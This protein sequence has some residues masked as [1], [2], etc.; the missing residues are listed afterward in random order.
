MLEIGS[1]IDG[2]YKILNKIGQGGMSVVYLAMNERAN[3]QWAI[4]EVRKDGV[5]NFEV[6]KQGLVAEV[7]MLKK[8]NHPHLPSI[9]DV[10]DGDDSFLIVMDYI[11]GVSLNKKLRELGAIPQ[12]NVIE[13]GKQLCDV[14][15]YL[16]SRTAP[17]IY[18]DM[19]P[20][21]VMLRPDGDVMLIDFG[22]AREFKSNSVADT[23][24]LG[25]QGYAAPEQFGGQGQTDARTDIYCLGATL[26]HL[27]TG[28]NPCEY[29][30]EMYP[31]RQ[32]NP[33]LSSGLEQIIQKCTQ[34]NPNDRYQSCAELM[35]ALDHYQD[36]DIES[37]K[38]MNV[39]WRSFVAASLAS[40]VMFGGAVGFK[41]KA[42][43]DSERAFN[44]NITHTETIEDFRNLV[45]AASA[46]PERVEPYKKAV[47]IILRDSQFTTTERNALLTSLLDPS[48]TENID[49]LKEEN[50]EYYKFCYD[51]G[52]AYF[53]Q[54][55]N[56]TTGIAN[57]Q[58]WLDEAAKSPE[59]ESTI[60]DTDYGMSAEDIK[61]A[62]MLSKL[63]GAVAHQMSKNNNVSIDSS[64]N[65]VNVGE[66]GP[67][68][69]TEYNEK[70]YWDDLTSILKLEFFNES[71]SMTK[72]R[73][74]QWI[75]AALQHNHVKMAGY[76]VTYSQM[77]EVIDKAK[78]DLN[79]I[80]I[81]IADT[82]SASYQE[83]K[84]LLDNYETIADM[85][86]D[87]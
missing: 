20:A 8:L 17:I 60:N 86:A 64:T 14:L 77:R 26:Y 3:K 54:Y 40:I 85:W 1:V 83:V 36:F 23:T 5:T 79:S 9:I 62:K 37:R 48:D 84:S 50:N 16:H 87:Q 73:V 56:Y 7:D 63:S 52:I 45:V 15:G 21:N 38:K 44:N 34:K 2:K 33:A 58:K 70:Q 4:K 71:N 57:C 46:F 30:Y 55:E 31:I 69:D 80:L 66:E 67:T 72:R 18:R 22:T 13:W 19:K 25:T 74:Y 75:H 32:W 42:N 43:S 29:P 11:E 49:T 6:V 27:V 35:Y 47:E 51:L 82:S 59:Y 78:S 76:G 28:H 41:I 65:I 39:K 61:N 12:E 24:C 53:F 68:G 10:I 81:G